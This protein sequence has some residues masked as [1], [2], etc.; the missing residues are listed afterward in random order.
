MLADI[1]DARRQEIAKSVLDEN[2]V[3]VATAIAKIYCKRSKYVQ[4]IIKNWR[5][6][7]SDVYLNI[8]SCGGLFALA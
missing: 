5:C 6:L 1:F 4:D 8:L 2:S 7:A 3:E